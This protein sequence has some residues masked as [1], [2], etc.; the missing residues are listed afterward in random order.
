[1]E[2][3]YSL[4]RPF[5]LE[6]AKAGEPFVFIENGEL[7]PRRFISGP[8]I[9]GGIVIKDEHGRFGVSHIKPYNMAPLTW[10]EGRPVYKGDVLY[11]K[12]HG[13]RQE[14][15]SIGAHDTLNTVHPRRDGAFII[16]LEDATWN[17]PKNKH[18]RWF[19]I[20]KGGILSMSFDSKKDADKNAGL[21]RIACCR[22]EWEEPAE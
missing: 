10:V 1:M 6:A 21:S 15:R 14:V 13:T 5:D 19:N 22:I 18:E 7:K 2:K 4:L 9:D 17:P 8:D 20:Y 3:D 11:C 16:C 12:Q